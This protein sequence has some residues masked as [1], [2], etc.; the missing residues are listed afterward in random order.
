MQKR[1]GLHPN[2]RKGE[3]QFN[4][5]K[6]MT[7]VK[8]RLRRVALVHIWMR[9]A[10]ET[11]GARSN[12]L[13]KDQIPKPRGPKALRLTPVNQYNKELSELPSVSLSGFNALSLPIPLNFRPIF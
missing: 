2:V 7:T 6:S 9:Y 3:L 1:E 12:M 4:S 11:P 10:T 8:N 5:L 13:Y